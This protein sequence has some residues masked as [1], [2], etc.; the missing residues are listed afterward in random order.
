MLF[1]HSKGHS[2]AG[3]LFNKNYSPPPTASQFLK[4]EIILDSSR[5]YEIFHV[6]LIIEF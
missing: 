6:V 1:I 5:L 3:T 4:S 2:E